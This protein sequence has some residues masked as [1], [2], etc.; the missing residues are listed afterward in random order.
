MSGFL[1]TVQPS[2]SEFNPLWILIGIAISSAL[3]TG[4]IWVGKVQSKMSDLSGLM[5]EIRDGLS[6]IQESIKELLRRL[7]PKPVAGGSPLQLTDLGR[8]IAVQIGADEWAW[9]KAEELAPEVIDFTAEFEF[10]AFADEYV[11]G[12][13]FK[14]SD[15]FRRK[16]GACAYQNGVS[17]DQ[18]KDVLVVVLRDVL[19]AKSAT[20]T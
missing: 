13:K 11:R 12:S 18:V 7:P 15:D 16:I 19:L 8:E 9:G 6:N 2:A 20:K 3:V 10:H 4:G 1:L 17:T 5:P 14:P